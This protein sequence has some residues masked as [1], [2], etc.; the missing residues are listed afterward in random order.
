MNLPYDDQA[1]YFGGSD[2]SELSMQF[3]FIGMQ[4]LYLSLA[5][6][7]AARSPRPCANGP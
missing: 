5:R 3:D 7:D 4:R 2:A 1:K 6:G